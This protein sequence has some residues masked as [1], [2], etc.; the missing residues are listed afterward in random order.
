[1]TKHNSLFRKKRI[2]IS[3]WGNLEASSVPFE[4]CKRLRF[5]FIV[6]LFAVRHSD[7]S[8]QK[9]QNWGIVLLT[10]ALSIDG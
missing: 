5:A 8:T 9:I 2:S 4:I 1:M 10:H 6:P 3:C 7:F